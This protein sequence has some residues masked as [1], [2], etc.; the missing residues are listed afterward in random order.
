MNTLT[1]EDKIAI[2]VVVKRH[3]FSIWLLGAMCG[4]AVGF[5]FGFGI[6]SW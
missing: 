1:P 6:G 5:V 2:E 4:V 3:F